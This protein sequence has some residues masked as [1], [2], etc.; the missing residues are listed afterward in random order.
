LHWK[1]ALLALLC[2]MAVGLPDDALGAQDYCHFSER[3]LLLFIDRTTQY[4]R[5]DREVFA[6]GLEGIFSS[7]AIGDELIVHTIEDAFSNSKQIFK[8][9][10]PG[11]PD[12]GLMGW[13]RGS[14]KAMEARGDRARFQRMLA[15]S[16]QNLLHSPMAFR[17]SDIAQT[18]MT[19]LQSNALPDR[20]VSRIFIFSDMLENSRELPWPA[21]LRT[22]AR[23]LAESLHETGAQIRLKGV[24][25]EVFGFGRS[26][27]D[28]RTPLSIKQRQTL[29]RF[30]DG[31]FGAFGAT[32]VTLGSRL[33][34]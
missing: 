17:H 9:C 21:V 27:D 28:A 2:W 11:C 15:A 12:Q 33:V 5:Q 20:P 30:W 26:H 24:S 14:C 31:Y 10:Y 8:E 1:R 6:E 29:V 16:G 34:R 18:I 32:S 3:R 13:I 4:D 7:L 22:P 25:I 23:R 19:V